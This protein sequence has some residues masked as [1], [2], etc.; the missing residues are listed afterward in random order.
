[1]FAVK[2]A[3]RPAIRPTWRTTTAFCPNDR[4][5]IFN[6]AYIYALP[7]MQGGNKIRGRCAVNGWQLSGI[8]IFQSGVNLQSAYSANFGVNG[9]YPAGDEAALMARL[10]TQNYLNTVNQ[11]NVRSGSRPPI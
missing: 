5:Q 11:G 9:D 7:S 8:T 1:M 4:S 3:R 6:L 10:L 2:A